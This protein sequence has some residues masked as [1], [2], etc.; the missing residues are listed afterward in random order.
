[1]SRLTADVLR[2]LS[3]IA[4]ILIHGTSFSQEPFRTA[5]NYIST[6]F[7]AVFLGQASRFSVPV[8][9]MLSGYGLT[10][11]Y[12][13]P[14]PDGRVRIPLS[15]FF[16][17]RASKILIPFLVWTLAMLLFT[18][19]LGA[20]WEATEPP[21]GWWGAVRVFVRALVFGGADYH[22][23]FF[24]II[25]QCYLLF[26]LLLRLPV[27]ATLAV[28]AAV[29]MSFASPLS[30]WLYEQG[31]RLPSL[32][33]TSVLYWLAY[34]QL[35]IATARA[36]QWVQLA[37]RLRHILALLAVSALVWVLADYIRR[38]YSGQTPGAYDHFNRLSV[39]AWACLFWF[40]ALG[41]ADRIEGFVH[42]TKTESH[43]QSLAA[44]SF[45]IYLIH[46]S[47]L[48]VLHL[49]PL[50]IMLL[51]L[52]VVVFS[53]ALALVLFHWVWRPVVLRTILGLPGRGS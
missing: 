2:V 14:G 18:G 8:F 50:N 49:I 34:F 30:G 40:A 31:V 21:G 44:V 26:P 37:G 10:L 1:M 6:D 24:S 4:V 38:S 17:S 3:T 27:Y 11:R 32:P 36:K 16:R 19:R 20:A 53:V 23:Y 52:L 45:T 12:A 43:V 48:R 35:G 51:N 28:T 41:W 42:R 22:L 39:V 13:T 29:Q 25:L 46:P 5:H 33:A 9:L 47:V 15:D 7:L